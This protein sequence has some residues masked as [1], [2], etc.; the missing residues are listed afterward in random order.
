MKK[1][2]AEIKHR[3]GIDLSGRKIETLLQFL[4]SVHVTCNPAAVQVAAA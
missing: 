4:L 2:K 3:A 1:A